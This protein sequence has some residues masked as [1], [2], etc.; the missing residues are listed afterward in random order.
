MGT[1]LLK[2]Q[3]CDCIHLSASAYTL[4]ISYNIKNKIN[5]TIP[6]ISCNAKI[7]CEAL[8]AAIHLDVTLIFRDHLNNVSSTLLVKALLEG[9]SLFQ[10]DSAQYALQ[11]LDVK[12]D[13][14]TWP[15]NFT[16]SD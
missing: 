10:L 15:S 13:L 4:P 14:L 11:K 2:L 6:I 1:I 5:R 7:C 16:H 3:W 8:G 9:S 12:P